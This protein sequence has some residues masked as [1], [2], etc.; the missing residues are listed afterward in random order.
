MRSRIL[1]HSFT[2]L[3]IVPALLLILA[4]PVLADDSDD[5]PE[6]KPRRRLDREILMELGRKDD[7]TAAWGW[8]KDGKLKIRGK[9]LQYRKRMRSG[10]RPLARCSAPGCV[11]GAGISM[12]SFRVGLTIQALM[13]RVSMIVMRRCSP[14]PMSVRMWLPPTNTCPTTGSWFGAL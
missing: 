2:I 13:C 3:L 11:G 5:V 12:N 4:T 9:G 10:G 7:E 14:V 8:L 6:L 1:S